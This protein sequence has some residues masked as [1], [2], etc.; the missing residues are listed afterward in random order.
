MSREKPCSWQCFL[1]HST[2]W[3]MTSIDQWSTNW[4]SSTEILTSVPCRTSSQLLNPNQRQHPALQTSI[5]LFF[6]L[7]SVFMQGTYFSPQV[8]SHQMTQR[9]SHLSL[10]DLA[11]LYPQAIRSAPVLTHCRVSQHKFNDGRRI[12]SPVTNKTP[13][14]QRH[15][16]NPSVSTPQTCTGK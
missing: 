2:H 7:T 16:G 8:W 9:T 3:R 6:F 15:Y 10:S 12:T 13:Q 11:S 5:Q 14:I 4:T 1:K